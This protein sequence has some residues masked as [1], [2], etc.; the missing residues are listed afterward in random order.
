MYK[1]DLN[2]D[3]GE[4]FG[5]YTIG[6]DERIIPNISSA[7]V[8]CG[9]HAG[10]PLIMQKTVRLCKEY[11][12]SVGAHP[13]Y[14]D[15]V[16]FGRRPMDISPKQ[17][18]AD[19]VYQIGALQA[20]CRMEQV[21]LVHVKLHGALY[22]RA[23]KDLEFSKVICEGIAALDANLRFMG[24]SGTEM[25]HAARIV[26]IDF[27]SEVFADRG[28]LSNGLLVPRTA[29]G[30]VLKDENQVI[31]RVIGMIREGQV[32]S[33]SGDIISI[34]ADTVCVHGDGEHALLFVEKLRQAF[35]D[36]AIEVG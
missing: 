8:A 20:F 28:Y 7:N 34:K 4:S 18:A 16:G 13:G 35:S 23:A 36:N 9:F 33:I 22:N 15:L 10:D 21:P 19:V 27:M 30:A 2:C 31:Q 32:E 26:G 3:L 29:E 11:G 6:M 5:A 24:Q 17:A 25:E 14:P 1:I 12:V